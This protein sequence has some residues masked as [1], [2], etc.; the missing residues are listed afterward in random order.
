MATRL[1]V[2]ARMVLEWIGNSGKGLD[3][4]PGEE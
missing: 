2:R 4:R 1:L 3:P